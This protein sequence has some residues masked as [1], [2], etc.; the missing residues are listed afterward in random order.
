[1]GRARGVEGRE[2]KKKCEMARV[3]EK[4]L[5]ELQRR[6]ARVSLGGL[7]GQEGGL[8]RELAGGVQK[9]CVDA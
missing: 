5:H 2:V 7:L 9:T 1:M 4:Q 3:R 6:G 8:G